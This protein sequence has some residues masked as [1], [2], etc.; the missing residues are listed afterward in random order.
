M[1]NHAF[2]RLQKSESCI[3]DVCLHFMHAFTLDEQSGS[4]A[5]MW[6]G[7]AMQKEVDTR[8]LTVRGGSGGICACAS[9]HVSMCV[10]ACE[11]FGLLM[12]DRLSLKFHVRR[13]VAL[14][15]AWGGVAAL[16]HCPTRAWIWQPRTARDPSK[17]QL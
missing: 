15:Q 2:Y 10:L 9:M 1:L 7:E 11:T 6:D 5:K 4:V 16:G 12:F 17:C 3:Q 8:V 13:I 14:V